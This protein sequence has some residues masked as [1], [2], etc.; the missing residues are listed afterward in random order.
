[1]TY[2][3]NPLKKKIK[4]VEEWLKREQMQIRTGRATPALLDNVKVE[5]YGSMMNLNQVGSMSTEDPRTLRVSVWDTTQLKAVEKAIIAANLGVAVAVDDK[6]IRVSFP[7]LT[8]ERR[9]SLI[10]IAKEK[11][12]SAR[13]SLRK[14]RDETWDDIQKKE[15]DGG[16]GEDEKFRFKTEMEKLIQEGNKMLDEAATRKEKEIM[17]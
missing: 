11:L 6:G 17:S 8:S 14:L 10:K 4:D 16:M 1:M 2:D 12:E 13:I 9:V 7:E 15:K 3:F 5:S